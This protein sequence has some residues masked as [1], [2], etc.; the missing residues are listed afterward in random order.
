MSWSTTQPEPV[1]WIASPHHFTRQA[2]TVPD[3]PQ[4]AECRPCTPSP[5]HS[6]KARPRNSVWRI[7]P[8][9]NG[10]F[11]KYLPSVQ[12]IPYLKKLNIYD[13]GMQLNRGTIKPQ[14][15]NVKNNRQRGH[16]IHECDHIKIGGDNGQIDISRCYNTLH[17][18]LSNGWGQ[19][20]HGW[21]AASQRE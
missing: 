21:T 1:R 16:E 15:E 9:V 6:P 3:Q 20:Q 18:L 11:Q 5:P 7:K 2:N 4:P 14:S 10:V 8:S 19:R 17:H 12:W 13:G